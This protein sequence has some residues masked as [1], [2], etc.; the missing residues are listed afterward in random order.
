MTGS[1]QPRRGR[2][3]AALACDLT[4]GSWPDPA[5]WLG[6]TRAGPVAGYW[7]PS[8]GARGRAEEDHDAGTRTRRGVSAHPGP[9]P[10]RP[11]VHDGRGQRSVDG[12]ALAPG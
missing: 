2:A 4:R 9:G 10:D 12:A 8:G 1:G 5:E 6:P 3:S 11:R 7:R